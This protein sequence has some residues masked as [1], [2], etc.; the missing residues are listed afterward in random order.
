MK[1]KGGVIGLTENPIALQRWL[2]CG[3]ELANCVSE[4]KTSVRKTTP[5]TLHHEEGFATQIKMK[6]QVESLV[7]VIDAFGNP[8]EDDCPELLVLNSRDCA[9]DSV[10]ATV[11]SIE[12]LGKSQYEKY[13][14]EVITDGTGS[15][16]DTITK[17]SLPLFRTPKRKAKSKSAQQLTTQRKNAGLFGRLYIANQQR[18]GDLAQFFRHE[19]QS[20]PPALSDCGEIRLGQKSA[21]LTCIDFAEQSNPP[22]KF[23]C[24]IF[25]GSTV[26]HFLVPKS[27]KTFADYANSIF[28]PFLL[29]QL[30][31]TSRIDCVWDRYFDCSIK[32]STRTR[33][34]RGVRTK[35]SGQTKLP[36]K[37]SDFLKVDANKTE[38]Y[39]FLSQ[40]VSSIRIP[41]HKLMF[42]TS[43]FSVISMGTDQPMPRCDHEE[44][45]TRMIVHVRDSLDRGNNQIMIRTVDTDVLIILIGQFHS[46]C[47]Q[48]PNADIWVGFGTGKQFRYYH[49]NTICEQLGKDKSVSLPRFHAFTGCVRHLLS[50]VEVRNQRGQPGCHTQR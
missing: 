1:G 10:I 12:V 22:N 32:A 47:E 14:A 17:N 26:V 28:V 16:H 24:K 31:G 15:I 23:D 19:N 36:K 44:A 50:L 2:I 7:G 43:E 30:E 25:D 41:E 45:D 49:I 38:L 11:R 13:V 3:P 39:H 18:E 40:Q 33:R 21:L 9:D 48:N 27:A 37:W 29:Q 42:I 5:P 35:V 20:I 8:F 34:G 6:Q 4:F 46:S